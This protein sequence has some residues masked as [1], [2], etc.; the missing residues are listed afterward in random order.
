MENSTYMVKTRYIDLNG[1]M[2]GVRH[3]YSVSDTLI[4]YSEEQYSPVSPTSTGTLQLGAPSLYKS[5]EES[6][7]ETSGLVADSTE[8]TYR[9]D[10]SWTKHGGK[11]MENWKNKVTKS[12]PGVRGNVEGYFRWKLQIGFWLY[13]TSIDPRLNSKRI[14]QM[15]R[16]CPKYNYMTK[17]DK[18]SAFAERLGHN[19]GTQIEPDNYFKCDYPT[20]YRHVI[21]STLR[22][23]S[24]QLNDYFIYVDHG[25]VIYLEEERTQDFINYAKEKSQGFTNYASEEETIIALFL[26][27]PKYKVQ[28]EYRFVVRVPFHSPSEDSFRF[29]VSEELKRLMSP[30]S[31]YASR[32]MLRKWQ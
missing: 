26:K 1:I 15:K 6:C 8:G 32:A 2:R 16:T 22:E 19:F 4:K 28:Q 18:P 25:P 14:E 23:Q 5:R 21:S 24:G 27:D 3:S 10:I 12:I 31:Y 29:N 11:G 13:C 20:L 30:I 17:I 7:E 9:E